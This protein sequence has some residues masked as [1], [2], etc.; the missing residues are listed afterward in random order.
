MTMK[1]WSLGLGI[2]TFATVAACKGEESCTVANV[3]YES[4]AK[5][6]SG[7]CN[8]CTCTDGEVSCSEMGCEAAACTYQGTRHPVGTSFPAGDGCNTCSCDDRG[9]VSCTL[10]ACGDAG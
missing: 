8:T 7:D 9:G 3:T 10:M 1:L 6:P 5:V 2:L 4:G